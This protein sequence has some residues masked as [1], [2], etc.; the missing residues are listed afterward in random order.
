MVGVGVVVVKATAT[1]PLVLLIRRGK[2][3]RAGS[4][5]IPGGRQELGE[6]L[7]A[8]ARREVLEET[9]VAL[10]DLQLL[11]VVDS[12]THDDEGRVS[13]HFSLIDFLGIWRSGTPSAASDAADARWVSPVDLEDYPLWSETRRVIELALARVGAG[14]G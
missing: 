7:K 8:A 6:T 13:H 9:G 5:S 14:E 12:V 11:D 1:G 3:P 10:A 4:W 2:A